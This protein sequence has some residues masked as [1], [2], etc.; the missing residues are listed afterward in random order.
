[1]I[2]H[3]FRPLAASLAISF[4]ATLP[5]F[6]QVTNSSENAE[7]YAAIG[8]WT[9]YVMSDGRGLNSCRAVRGRAYFDQI[10]VEYD[11]S[12][13]AWQI[14]T[15]GSRPEPTGFGIKAAMVTFDSTARERQIG[16]GV[17]GT[18][19]ASDTHA[20]LPLDQDEIGLFMNAAALT[21]DINGEAVRSWD[22]K[23]SKAA[24]LK[25]EECAVSFGIKPAHTLAPAPAPRSSRP[26]VPRPAAP[27]FAAPNPSTSNLAAP[28]RIGYVVFSA[29]ELKATFGNQWIGTAP[30]GTVV[31]FTEYDRTPESIFLTDPQTNQQLWLDLTQFEI[32]HTRNFD[33]N[34]WAVVDRID[35]ADTKPGRM[36]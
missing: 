20:K 15:Q 34:T 1:M 18:D 16:F 3:V 21:L 26:A 2:R 12:L 10:M 29:G 35:C 9:V 22:L 11:G 31:T 33:N 27:N 25:V 5:S 30:D 14:L 28:D 24:A 13:A 17:P 19:G 8:D 32:L 7:H 23:G 6:G 36:C 4:S